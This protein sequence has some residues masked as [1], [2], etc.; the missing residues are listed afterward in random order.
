MATDFSKFTDD[1][2]DA[3]VVQT[4]SDYVNPALSQVLQFIGFSSFE[5]EAKGSIVRDSSGREFLDCLGG[6]GT[7]SLGHSHPKIVAA[8]KAQLDRMAFSSRVL[9]NAPQAMLAKKL[10]EVTPGELHYSFFCNSGAEAA[11][12]A[13]KFAR[14]HTK[15]KKLVSAKGAYHGKTIGAL[16]VSG[17]D[18]Y[19]TPFGPLVQ[20]V[21]TVEFNDIAQLEEAIDEDTAAFLVEP[22]QGEGGIY[23]ASNEYLQAARRICDEKGALL[24]FDEVQCGLGRTGKMWGCD[25]AGV[26]PDMML[27]AKALSG[28]A[29]PIGAVVARREI[30][31]FWNDAPLIHSSTFG[32]NPL[33][34]IAGLA[35]LEIIEE[36]NLVERCA[37]AG[38]MLMKGLCE[39]QA[40]FPHLV[41][42]IRG[43]GL[44]IGV[45]FPLEDITS[46]VL[47]GLA[48]RDVLVV[49]YT[50]NNPTV[51]RFEPP[52]NISDE[53]IEWALKAFDESVSATAELIE[54]MEIEEAVGH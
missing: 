51:T 6:Y 8:C 34:C 41:K 33:A 47:A 26:A 3:Q 39:T 13:I 11:E 2:S 15:R 38:D 31:E 53:H 54:G 17:R 25:W 4:Y 12:A 5:V 18:K 48:Q 49:P 7:M 9:F 30:W 35:T 46:L 29:I 44:M 10:A 45:E 27:L 50:F 36:E 43:R 21:Q 52:L 16:S 22:V 37:R 40:K 28:G 1:L 19:K 23:T 32:G 42:D 14:I 20:D 24:V